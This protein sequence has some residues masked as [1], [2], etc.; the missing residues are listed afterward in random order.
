[1]TGPPEKSRSILSERTSC[2]RHD[3]KGSTTLHRVGTDRGEQNERS[4]GMTD[5]EVLTCPQKKTST[6]SEVDLPAVHNCD[7]EELNNLVLSRLPGEEIHLIGVD[8]PA[9]EDE[10]IEGMSC[11]NEEHLHTLTRSN[12][13]QYEIRLKRGAI[14]MFLRNIDVTSQLSSGTR[15]EFV[16]MRATY[17]SNDDVRLRQST[18]L[19]KSTIAMEDLLS[20]SCQGTARHTQERQH[21]SGGE[22]PCSS[23]TNV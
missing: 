21:D 19:F 9:C 8:T 18:T 4:L 1:M 20:G 22:D 12:M 13:P 11:D 16:Q 23:A 7:V 10:G 5:R 6:I 17:I 2:S 15:L 14:I 3:I